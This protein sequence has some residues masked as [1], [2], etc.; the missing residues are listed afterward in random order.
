MINVKMKDDWYIPSEPSLRENYTRISQ[1]QNL[2]VVENA[3]A[4]QKNA[5]ESTRE[6]NQEQRSEV[7]GFSGSSATIELRSKKIRN[8]S[9]KK[10]L[11][12]PVLNEKSLTILSKSSVELE[13]VE[14]ISYKRIL[15]TYSS[16]S[17]LVKKYYSEPKASTLGSGYLVSSF[18]QRVENTYTGCW[19]WLYDY[20]KCAR[21]VVYLKLK[22]DYLEWTEDFL[23]SKKIKL[24]EQCGLLI[25]NKSSTFKTKRPKLEKVHG[26]VDQ[27]YNCF[28]VVGRTRSYDFCT[29]TENSAM[30][31][32]LVLSQKISQNSKLSCKAVSKYQY[33]VFSI[34]AKILKV[35]KE[36]YLS[37]NELWMLSICKTCNELNYFQEE[38]KILSVIK[39]KLN[40]ESRFRRLIDIVMQEVN[41]NCSKK[42]TKFTENT[43][44]AA[45]TKNKYIK[46]S[47]L[48]HKDQNPEELP[49]DLK[50]RK[51][52][53]LNKSNQ[54]LRLFH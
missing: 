39:T 48:I 34:R 40:P 13:E 52:F 47:E 8:N 35:A 33:L 53:K 22:G 32:I 51:L 18:S 5:L 29:F 54:N 14:E 31:F 26:K 9:H 7:S 41:Y 24:T 28:S 10:E 20:Y 6:I 37:V 27:D 30:D 23:Q 17:L 38:S 50:F 11:K 12:L 46:I 16:M 44:I 4:D 42:Q 43:R 21:V 15:L 3:F 1:I 25:G 19:V 36:K 2:E 49:V 45:L